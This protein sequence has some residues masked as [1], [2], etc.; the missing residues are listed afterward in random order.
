MTEDR[1]SKLVAAFD[2]AIKYTP[3]LKDHPDWS[4]KQC[5]AFAREWHAVAIDG[6]RRALKIE[7]KGHGAW[8]QQVP[9][10]SDGI[11][12]CRNLPTPRLLDE[13]RK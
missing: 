7:T 8:D 5:L 1:I 12:Y 2:G 4:D 11:P 13:A 9:R 3:M 10:W 6:L